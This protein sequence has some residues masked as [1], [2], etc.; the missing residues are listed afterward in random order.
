M[1]VG[2]A[3][4]IETGV[5]I[6]D[7]RNPLQ[8]RLESQLRAA[9]ASWTWEELDPDVFGAELER[10]PYRDVERIAVVGLDATIAGA[11]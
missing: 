5:P 7:G 11:H 4:S 9:A 6:I 10:E 3:G 1:P 2:K 8:D